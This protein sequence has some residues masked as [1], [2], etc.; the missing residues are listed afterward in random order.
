LDLLVSESSDSGRLGRR[1]IIRALML[2]ST[3]STSTMDIINGQVILTSLG[4]FRVIDNKS[5]LFL[6]E[7][8]I[9][10][11][12]LLDLIEKD[13]NLRLAFYF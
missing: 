7:H 2:A 1:A 11:P 10:I 4:G 8:C 12:K 3:S 13:D 9:E 6:F 5:F